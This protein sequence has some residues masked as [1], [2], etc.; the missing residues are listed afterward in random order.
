MLFRT[1]LTGLLFLTAVAMQA[2]FS[3]QGM[4]NS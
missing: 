1:S 2:Q 4:D 3:A